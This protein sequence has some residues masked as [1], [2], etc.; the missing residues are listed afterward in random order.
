MCMCV[1]VYVLSTPEAIITSGMMW[2]D[3]DLMIG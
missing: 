2:H 1:Y 3:I